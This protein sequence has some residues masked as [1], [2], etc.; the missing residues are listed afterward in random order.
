MTVSNGTTNLAIT[1]QSHDNDGYGLA[2][3]LQWRV[4]GLQAGTTYTVRVTGVT[5]APNSDYS[6]TFRITS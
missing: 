5:G 2:N 6:Y 3:N 4:T 1:D